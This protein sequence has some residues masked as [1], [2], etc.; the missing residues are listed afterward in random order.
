MSKEE[1][2]D[3]ARSFAERDEEQR[4][5][6]T[7][8]DKRGTN[9]KSNPLIAPNEPLQ[10][11]DCGEVP[12][13][14]RGNGKS[15][16][17]G[18]PMREFTDREVTSGIQE[19]IAQAQAEMEAKRKANNERKERTVAAVEEAIW[20][21][22]EAQEAA[23][24]GLGEGMRMTV[25]RAVEFIDGVVDMRAVAIAACSAFGAQA[26][27]NIKATAEEMRAVEEA[28]KANRKPRPGVKPK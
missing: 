6:V 20:V 14:L 1:F 8:V 4:E 28:Q 18:N 24:T 17:S 7:I 3:Q 10:A 25:D 12:E 16:G 13:A 19:G 26:L 23:H 5:P 21:E 11:P 22:L 2:T 9:K 27:M 15:N